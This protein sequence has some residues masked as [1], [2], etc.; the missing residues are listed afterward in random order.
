LPNIEDITLENWP[1]SAESEQPESERTIHFAIRQTRVNLDFYL[2][3]FFRERQIKFHYFK[4]F[5]ELVTVCHRNEV[6]AILI[7]GDGE[8]LREL[9]LVRAIKKNILLSIVPVILY[10]PEPDLN[11]MVAAYESGAE[12]FIHGEWVKKLVQVRIQRVIDRS[13]RDVAVNPSTLLPGPA[14]IEGE[15]NRQIKAGEK[16]AV[17]YADL[18]NFKAFNDYQGYVYGDRVIRMTGRILRDV[19][20]ELCREGFVGHI[21][22]D[23][24]IFVV[25]A[26]QAEPA[27]QWIIKS[28]DAFMPF[29]YNETDRARG[30]YETKNRRGEIE[31]FPLLSISIAVVINHNGEFK[32]M[33]ELSKM[34]ADLKRA[35]KA[36]DGSNYMIERRKKY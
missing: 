7:A 12:E 11:T 4:S 3:T 21:A 1:V 6:S 19:V 31:R 14:M 25:P 15:I 8:F 34:L 36:K 26:E 35:C 9:D 20:F 28:F 22:G 16:F 32:H 18:D 23:D 33:G 13:R 30:Y 10:H 5:D 17:C 27:C 2:S 24:F 29:Q